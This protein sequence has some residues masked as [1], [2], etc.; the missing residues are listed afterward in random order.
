MT[1]HGRELTARGRT[2]ATFG[3]WPSAGSKASFGAVFVEVSLDPITF[4]LRVDRCVGAYACGR[5]IEPWIARNQMLGGMVWGIGQALYEQTHVDP[6]TG[7]WV[8]ANLAEALVSTNADAHEVRA[9]FVEEDDTGSHPL[10]FKG[11]A[12]LGVIGP[13]PA[14]SNAILDA[15]GR[16]VRD[17]PMLIEHRLPPS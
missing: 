6:R 1:R 4:E 3:Y 15:T 17:L 11:L 2:G 16:R 13:A 9:M 8:N 12:E 7:H 14:I 10:G 5:I